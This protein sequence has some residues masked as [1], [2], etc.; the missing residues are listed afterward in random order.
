MKS[1][2]ISHLS[3]TNTQLFA[4]D[5]NLFIFGDNIMSVQNEAVHSITALIIT[6][7]LLVYL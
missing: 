7:L 6:D 5:T 2:D 4:D 1:N 3:P